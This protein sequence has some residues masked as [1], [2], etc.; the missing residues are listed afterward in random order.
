MILRALSLSL[1][2][3]AVAAP[4]LA[5]SEPFKVF[6]TRPV[7]TEGP[8]LVATSETTATIVWLTDTPSHAK[9]RYGPGGN[10]SAVAEPQL[11]GLVPVGTRHVVHLKGLSPGTIYGYEVVATRVVKLNAY[12]P[13]KGLDARSGPHQF[14]TFDRD[15]PSVS[16]SVVTDTHEDTGLIDRLNE[17]IDWESTDFLVH[18]GDAFDWVGSEE[19]LF[20]AWLRPTS[21]GLAH[22]KPLIFVRGNHE[23][24]G[25]FARHLLDY[26]PTPEG[27]FYYARDA[28]PVHLMVLDTG[29]DKPDDTNVYAEL[30]RTVPY[31]A[32][33][34][35]WFREH[36]N[37]TARVSEAPFR[38]ILM[39][40]PEWGWLADGSE[41]W[42]ETANAAGVDLVIAGHRHRFS[43]TPPGPGVEHAYHLLVV[44]K[45]QVARVKAT[46]T[47]LEVVVSGT[48]G[49]LV[50]TLVIPRR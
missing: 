26:V 8:Y 31:R 9:V 44:G 41:A 14:T 27:R 16:F 29:E 28:G 7:I 42:I 1:A 5:Q 17:A 46:P 2:M 18:A 20:R 11:D 30:N 47:E 19:H 4:A 15:S 33:E 43:H 24:R 10:L 3:L 34:L 48:D 22:S 32:E 38:V 6:D 25:P 21:V 23:L 39:H 12:W 40:Q 36:V 49:S 35:A 37:T 50:H 13:D 45:D